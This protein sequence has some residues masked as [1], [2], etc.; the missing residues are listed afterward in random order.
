MILGYARVSSKD[1]N[2]DRQIEKFKNI[3][4]E[5]R[6]IFL[7]KAIGANFD[8]PKYQLMKEFIRSGDLIYMDSLDRLGRTYDGIIREWK[9]ITRELDA[10]IIILENESLFDSRKFKEMGDLGKLMEDQ[11][12]SLLAYVAEVERKKIKQR[13]RE[14]IDIAKLKGKRFGRP[15][16]EVPGNFNE[17]YQ[18][19]RAGKIKAVEAMKILNLKKSTFYKLINQ[20][21]KTEGNKNMLWNS[22]STRLE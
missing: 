17:V 13:Q 16:I 21:N 9:Y 4:I 11:F 8:R 12:L 6:Y 3:G 20:R 14:G 22:T 10:D 2:E 15:Q 1:Q 19:W 18:E 5:E 7:D